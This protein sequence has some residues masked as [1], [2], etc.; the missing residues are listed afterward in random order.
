MTTP[1]LHLKSS[2]HKP[3]SNESFVKWTSDFLWHWRNSAMSSEEA[4]EIILSNL[5][6]AMHPLNDVQEIFR[7]WDNKQD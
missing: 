2:G 4:A 6:K 7:D 3:V 5:E 1:T